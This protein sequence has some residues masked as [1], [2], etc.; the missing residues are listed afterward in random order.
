MDELVFQHYSESGVFLIFSI[1][2]LK[3]GSP[4]DLFKRGKKEISEMLLKF[5]TALGTAVFLS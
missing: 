2:H 1:V 3:D 5:L 4:R